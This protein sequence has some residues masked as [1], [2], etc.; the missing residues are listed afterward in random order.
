M[1][2]ACAHAI[3]CA[4]THEQCGHGCDVIVVHHS[5]QIQP[6]VSAY[7][8]DENG[9]QTRKEVRQEKVPV[10]YRIVREIFPRGYGS[11][12]NHENNRQDDF[13]RRRDT[14][15]EKFFDHYEDDCKASQ[16]CEHGHIDA[17]K[18]HKRYDDVRYKNKR[19]GRNLLGKE[20]EGGRG[21]SRCWGLGGFIRHA[22]R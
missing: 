4:S 20:R 5:K 19:K 10:R 2:S 1:W 9:V 8:V 21:P 7:F 17:P 3:K 15:K 18:G 12:D 13:S 6:R 11:T 16:G 22:S 14:E